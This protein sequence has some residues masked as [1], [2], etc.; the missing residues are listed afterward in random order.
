MEY[1]MVIKSDLPYISYLK[2]SYD[3]IVC[4]G[5]VAIFRNWRF[6]LIPGYKWND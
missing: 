3:K 2:E 6:F 4:F 1:A 5:N